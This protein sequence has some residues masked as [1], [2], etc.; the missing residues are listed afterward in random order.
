MDGEVKAGK[1]GR[2]NEGKGGKG[3]KGF[4]VR[5]TGEREGTCSLLMVGGQK[6]I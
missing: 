4:G 6:G 1:G 3:R 2:V 5:E